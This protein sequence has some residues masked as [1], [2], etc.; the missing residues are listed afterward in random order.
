[1]QCWWAGLTP[2]LCPS[3]EKTVT[4]EQG[5]KPLGPTPFDITVTS[6]LGWGWRDVPAGGGGVF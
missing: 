1:M 3:V 2:S 6:L 4:L 5:L